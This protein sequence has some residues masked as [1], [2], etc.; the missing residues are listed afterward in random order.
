MTA[1]FGRHS[2]LGVGG[3]KGLH[4]FSQGQPSETKLTLGAAAFCIINL[5]D[6]WAGA[7]PDC[8]Q[9]QGFAQALHVLSRRLP[10]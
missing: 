8:A 3:S 1:A 7:N 6:Y 9:L 10:E 2:S 4:S 5:S